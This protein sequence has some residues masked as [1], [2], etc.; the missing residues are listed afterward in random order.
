MT[1]VW[2]YGADAGCRMAAW[3]V[4]PTQT[5]PMTEMRRYVPLLI[6]GSALIAAGCRDVVA[7]TRQTT[8]AAT[9][10][11]LFGGGPN[12][13]AFLASPTEGADAVTVTFDLSP[14]G[15]SVKVGE[16]TVDYEANAVCDPSTA[17][18]GPATWALRCET[19]TQPITMTARFWKADGRNYADFYPDI[20]FAPEKNV[21]LSVSRP[22]IIGSGLTLV[23]LMAKYPVWYTMR[24]DSYRF[25]IDEEWSDPSLAARYD[26]TAGTV[27]RRIGHFSGYVIRWGYCEEFPEDPECAPAP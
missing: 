5:P 16:F 20:R 27:S 14:D 1:G 7:P 25:F 9:T 13:F 17:G 3:R 26:T 12:S 19:L 15:G 11:R 10:I 24:V 22:E 4:L 23:E 2:E 6:A 18:Y 8:T 21:V